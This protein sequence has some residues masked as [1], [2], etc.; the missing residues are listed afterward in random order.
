MAG[1]KATNG[2]TGAV[3]GKQG[4]AQ[5]ILEAGRQLARAVKQVD[6]YEDPDGGFPMLFVPDGYDVVDVEEHLPRPFRLKQSVSLD[7][8]DALVTYLK[9]FGDKERTIVFVDRASGTYRAAIDYHRAHAEP[10]WK[11]HNATLALVQT[12]AWKDWQGANLQAK[13]QFDF[14]QFIEDHIPEIAD[15]AG[16]LLMD[17]IMSFEAHR[18]AQF[19]ST[20][21]LNDGTVRLT[22]NEE[23]S[24]SRQGGEVNVPTTF[25]LYLAPYEGTASRIITARL[26]YRLQGAN[27][28]LW[29]DILRL[30]EV[31]EQAVDEVTAGLKDKAGEFVRAFVLGR[32]S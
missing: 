15:P 9:E 30:N 16:G 7:T 17:L 6:I 1:T 2:T 14:A 21:R 28:Q 18:S 12:Q 13:N 11:G 20:V 5:T 26:R 3:I 19:A 24:G 31:R 23:I 27:L 10:S 29:F 32:Q 25:K 8:P 4:D 22:F